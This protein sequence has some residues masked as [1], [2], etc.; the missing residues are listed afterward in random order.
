M[1][2]NIIQVAN[3]EEL[4]EKACA[5]FMQRLKSMNKP[6][7]GLATGSTPKGMY[8]C[9]VRE[10][11]KNNIDFSEATFFNLDEYV[12]LD[13][14]HPSSYAYYLKKRFYKPVSLKKGQYHLPDG[15]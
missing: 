4:S 12:G 10:Y 13:P 1:I 7:F 6:V 15:N 3:E 8:A 2:L 14:N 9:L 11:L 5:M